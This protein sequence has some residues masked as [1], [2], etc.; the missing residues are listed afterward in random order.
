MAVQLLVETADLLKC[1]FALSPLWETVAAVRTL[2]DPR[3]QAYHLPWL[4]KLRPELDEK[5]LSP[6]LTLLP[7]TGYTPDFLTPPPTGPLSEIE[8]E[9]A[10][11]ADTPLAHVREELRRCLHGPERK[12]PPRP[13]VA[14]RLLADPARTLAQLVTLIRTCWN[15][16]IAPQWP[17]LR[18]L[19]DADIAVR[20]RQ[21]A[22]GGLH[23]MLTELHPTIT[24]HEPG[25]LHIAAPHRTRHPLGGQGLLLLPSAFVWPTLT[26]VV[27]APW[28]PTLIY[29]ARGVGDL[30]QSSPHPSASQSLQR[31][32]GRTR[33][34][35]LTSL[36]KPVS[37][38]TLAR[39][40][41]LSPATVSGHLT[42]LRDADL[43]T[44]YRVGRTVYYAP[45]A[46][47]TALT[48]PL[49][50]EQP[51]PPEDGI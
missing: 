44:R 13:E 39:N 7:R 45:T 46:L 25:A 22:E 36:H 1:R 42:A 4:R 17:Q 14:D 21:L 37:T 51:I 19:L 38:S 50:T 31:L 30:W 8:D 29:P 18:D 2:A 34:R 41:S 3:R 6:L 11:V 33:A 28:Q 48:S 12:T 26:V 10:R 49:P 35:V 16:L 23:R 32:I 5:Q 15:W 27:E 47:G 24:W 20:S 43:V 9:L 40:L